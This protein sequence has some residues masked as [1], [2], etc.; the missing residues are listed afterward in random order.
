MNYTDLCLTIIIIQG[1]IAH[2]TCPESMK[3]DRVTIPHLMQMSPQSVH[4]SVVYNPKH[5][6][7]SAR[8]NT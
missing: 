7:M 8:D 5:T 2:L 3:P 4:V 6:L 1:H